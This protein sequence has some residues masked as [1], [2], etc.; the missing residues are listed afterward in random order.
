MREPSSR[1]D[2]APR[3]P[4]FA[5][6]GR[7][8]AGYERFKPP[9]EAESGTLRNL[10]RV[11]GKIQSPGASLYELSDG[12]GVAGEFRSGRHRAVLRYGQHSA[13]AS[14][15]VYASSLLRK[16]VPVLRMQR[17]HHQGSQRRSAIYRNPGARN[18]A[19]QPL[20]LAGTAHRAISLGRRNAHVPDS[21]T[22]GE[23]VSL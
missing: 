1:P 12:A 3:S 15:A 10:R 16:L 5:W 23:A 7:V 13:H 20:R 4:M 14:F 6:K 2:K 21:R 18:R 19:R 9:F 8:K 11:S 22:N 17:G